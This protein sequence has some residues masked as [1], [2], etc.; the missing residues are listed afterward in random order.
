MFEVHSQEAPGR[1]V[2][3]RL[4]GIAAF[5]RPHETAAE[6]PCDPAAPGRGPAAPGSVRRSETLRR[7]IEAGREAGA[8]DDLRVTERR[9][10]AAVIVRDG[11]VLMVRERSLGPS[12]RH[13]G[14][15]YWTLPGGGIADGETPEEAVRREVEEEVG[16]T[17]LSTRYL[18]D[19]PYPSGLTAC[20]AVTVADG[21]PPGRPRRTALRLPEPGFGGL[22]PAAS[23]EPRNNGCSHPNHDR[24]VARTLTVAQAVQPPRIS[25]RLTGERDDHNGQAEA[26]SGTRW[27]PHGPREVWAACGRLHGLER[28]RT[29]HLT[30]VVP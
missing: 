8:V 21:E 23:R 27:G 29:A 3:L 19:V 2:Q 15:E 28:Y 24:G 10:A 14:L 26:A 25:D 20:F 22:G 17:P 9:R 5:G 18:I 13:D 4:P 16:L 1:P 11:C 7:S 30:A 6:H 12:G